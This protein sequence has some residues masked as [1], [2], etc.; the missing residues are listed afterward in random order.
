M[1]IGGHVSWMY[2]HGNAIIML[3]EP[4]VEDVD[5]FAITHAQ[6]IEPF[7]VIIGV[8]RTFKGGGKP[9][10]KLIPCGNLVIG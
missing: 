6:L 10:R 1:Q 3:D 2:S 9:T 8:I 4:Q 7:K 5:S